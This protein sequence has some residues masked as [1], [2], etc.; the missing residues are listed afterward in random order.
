MNY[1]NMKK[2]A[3]KVQANIVCVRRASLEPLQAVDQP[4]RADGPGLWNLHK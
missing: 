3:A 2:L 4:G 1:D